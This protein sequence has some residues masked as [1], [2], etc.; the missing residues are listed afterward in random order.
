MLKRL[1]VKRHPISSRCSFLASFNNSEV[2]RQWKTKRIQT[3]RWWCK[4]RCPSFQ[5]GAIQRSQ[6]TAVVLQDFLLEN[7]AVCISQLFSR[8]IKELRQEVLMGLAPWLTFQTRK[9]RASKRPLTAFWRLKKQI[10]H[11]ILTNK[12]FP[13]WSPK[14]KLCIWTSSTIL[15]NLIYSWEILIVFYVLI[16]ISTKVLWMPSSSYTMKKWYISQIYTQT[17]S[18]RVIKK[19]I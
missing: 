18:W 1:L 15:A 4:Q 6:E 5:H 9:A 13:I 7:P 2:R 3:L 16:L 8:K 17:W 19:I 14:R 10:N 11:R 12:L